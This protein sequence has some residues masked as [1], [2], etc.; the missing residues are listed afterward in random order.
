MVEHIRASIIIKDVKYSGGYILSHKLPVVLIESCRNPIRA[1]G[2]SS[3][4][5][6]RGKMDFLLGVGFIY[7]LL[8]PMLHL[9]VRGYLGV[10]YVFLWNKSLK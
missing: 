9:F 8:H 1:R 6:L 4:K 2:S 10:S 3:F 7:V 5:V